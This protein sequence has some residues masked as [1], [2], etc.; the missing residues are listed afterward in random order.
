MTDLTATKPASSAAWRATAFTVC[1]VG[2]AVLLVCTEFDIGA[3]G[4]PRYEAMVALAQHGRIEPMK[5]SYLLP[6]TGVPL[7]WLGQLFGHAKEFASRLNAVLFLAGL[8]TTCALLRGLIERDTRLRFALLLMAASMFS[9]RIAWLYGDV[10]TAMLVAVG[11]LCLAVGRRKTGWAL[12]VLGTVNTPACIGGLA[13][14][15][16]VEAWRTGRWKC[17][18]PLALAGALIAM[19]RRLGT[20]QWFLSGYGG[21]EEKGIKTFMPYS[22]KPGFSYPFVFGVASIL[23]SFGRG[24]LFFAPGLLFI[25]DLFSG[26][27]ESRLRHATRLWLWFLVGLVLVYSKWW[28]WYG[29]W[30]WGP[31][32]FLLASVPASLA[33]AIRLSTA[34]G[35]PVRMGL[36]AAVLL[37]STWVGLSGTALWNVNLEMLR[38]KGFLFESLGWYTPEFSALGRPLV[39]FPENWPTM[40]WKEWT[41]FAWCLAAAATAAGPWAVAAGGV[42]WRHLREIVRAVFAEPRWRF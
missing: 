24:L 39:K 5:Y 37:L 10:L 25:R 22:D 35:A 29:G 16:A 41:I 20:G 9:G 1:M 14:L 18:L 7:Y 40:S 11:G 33:L 2:A 30:G 6:L 26:D 27:A 13:L 28:S 42:M 36:T 21:P 23:F 4:K 12:L 34:V 17:L 8:A 3:D 19:D 38:F 15:C 32:F 31:R